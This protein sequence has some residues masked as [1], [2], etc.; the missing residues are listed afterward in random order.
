MSG[1]LVRKKEAMERLGIHSYPTFNALMSAENAPKP[2]IQKGKF[3]LWDYSVIEQFLDKMGNI[4]K[5][6]KDWDAELEERLQ[7]R[8]KNRD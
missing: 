2:V 7:K 6:S 8:G 4:N 1:R 5:Q 3:I